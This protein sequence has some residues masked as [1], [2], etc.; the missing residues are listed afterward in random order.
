MQHWGLI[1][2]SIGGSQLSPLSAD[3]IFKFDGPMLTRDRFEE[4]ENNSQDKY[5]CFPGVDSFRADS[6]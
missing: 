1:T 2:I 4:E 3:D 5:T 6:F